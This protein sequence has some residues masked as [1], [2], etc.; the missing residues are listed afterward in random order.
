MNGFQTYV[1]TIRHLGMMLL[2]VVSCTRGRK[3][4]SLRR[5]SLRGRRKTFQEAWVGARSGKSLR[6]W[7]YESI[8]SSYRAS[9]YGY[10]HIYRYSCRCWHSYESKRITDTLSC[11]WSPSRDSAFETGV[12]LNH[13]VHDDVL[14]YLEEHVSP[15]IR[16]GLEIPQIQDAPVRNTSL[17]ELRMMMCNCWLLIW[18]PSLLLGRMCKL[19]PVSVLL[20]LGPF[21][22]TK[23]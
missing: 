22:W 20:L 7:F 15:V 12:E 19:P 18:I 2:I 9:Y 21:S 5:R 13:V 23:R 6:Y 14:S 1:I 11:W 16:E 3:E 17:V 10:R 8:F 4:L